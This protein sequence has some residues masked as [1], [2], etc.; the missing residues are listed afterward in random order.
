MH[1]KLAFNW[2]IKP[3]YDVIARL[4]GSTFPD[5]WVVRGNHHDAWVNGAEDPVSG[6]AAMLEEARALGEL[7]KQGWTPKRTIVYCAWDGEEPALLGSTEW[8]ET[9]AAELQQTRR[10]YI[11]TDGNGRGFLERRRLA[12]ARA[13][14]QRRGA[15]HPGSGDEADGLEARAGAGD[16]RAAPPTSAERRA[17][18]AD[19]RIGALGSGS[20]YTPFLQHLGIPSLNLGFGGEDDDGIYHSIY[21]DFYFYTH[22]LDTDFVY[23]RALAQT[24]GTAVI[25][26]ADADVLPFQFTNLADTVETYDEELQ[27]SAE[28]EARR[29]ARAQP[30]DR[31]WRVRRRSPIR[32]SRAPRRSPS[33][34]RRRS[35]SRRS[36]TPS[37]C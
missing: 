18:G 21:D 14:H 17:T 25:R 7:R 26:L 11:N 27:R 24:A 33:R 31:G 13:L 8:A 36:K 32:G 34:C 23:G 9:H 37:R 12:R 28:E 22:F 15:G 5:E 10:R 2:D 4:P 29:S 35:T 16:R 3:L 6:M 19:L 20:D 30:P 1:L